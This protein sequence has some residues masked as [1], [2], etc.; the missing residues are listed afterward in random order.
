MATTKG[1]GSLRDLG[2]GR[3]PDGAAT[4]VA[5]TDS[6]GGT[7]NDT[8]EAI[9]GVYSQTEVRNNFADLAAKVNEI[10]TLLQDIGVRK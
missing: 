5:L 6:S 7:A 1:R 3:E 10:L 2:N 8:L 9:G 4:I